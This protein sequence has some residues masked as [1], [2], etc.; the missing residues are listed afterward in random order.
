MKNAK[1]KT[2]KKIN[3]HQVITQKEVKSGE[4]NVKEKNSDD[5]VRNKN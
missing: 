4:V 1:Q 5:L 3:K 2:G